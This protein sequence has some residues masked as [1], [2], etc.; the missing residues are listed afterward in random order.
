MRLGSDTVAGLEQLGSL[1]AAMTIRRHD[2]SE[3]GVV[4]C[5]P[6]ASQQLESDLG[7]S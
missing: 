7:P 3:A 5:W 2:G 6:L 4:S 1:F